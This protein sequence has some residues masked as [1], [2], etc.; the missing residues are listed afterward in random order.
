MSSEVSFGK[1]P[2]AI[3]SGEKYTVITLSGDLDVNAGK[4]FEKKTAGL[5]Q[6]NKHLLFDF[7]ECTGIHPTW[8][9][10]FLGL[11]AELK[12]NTKSLRFVAVSSD[13][14]RNLAD[15]GIGQSIKFSVS[16]TSAQ[17]DI[18]S[19]GA[20]PPKKMDVKFVNAF[21]DAVIK[22]MKIQTQ[23]EVQAGSPFLKDP[24]EGFTGDISGVIG[25]VS[26]AFN[27]AIVINFPEKTFLG[28]ISR[29]LGEEFK[30]L[31]PEI[32]DGAAEL[33]NIIFGQAKVT[34]NELGYGI[35][36]ATPSVVTGKNH[37]ISSA[38]NGP[39]IT[40]PFSCDLGKFSVEICLS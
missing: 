14:Q 13:I 18:E 39:R 31:T 7:T 19:G 23:T 10:L 15:Q 21:L 2:F 29:M 37:T 36:M 8:V 30:V 34:L 35:K 24:K 3:K 28:V 32:S 40:V 26:D 6:E 12:K 5:V 25:L 4:E 9:R 1:A 27:G 17:Q 16:I 22:V 11:V 38:G 20:A 33:T